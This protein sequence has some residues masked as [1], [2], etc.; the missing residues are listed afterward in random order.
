MSKKTLALLVSLLLVTVVLLGLALNS[1]KNPA[2]QTKPL[3]LIGNPEPTSV[4]QT[5]MSMSPSTI[6][7]GPSGTGTVDVVLTTDVNEVSAV[8]LELSYDPKVLTGVIV[9]QGT[10]FDNPLVLINTNDTK[11]GRISYALGVSQIQASHKGTGTVATISFRKAAGASVTQ[12]K[13]SFLPKSLVSAKG[14]S[15]SVLKSTTDTTIT[16]GQ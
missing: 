10:F 3:P 5:I 8:Q 9:K 13:I 16:L 15:P 1:S 12:T 4:E 11:T 2:T 6:Q 14:V 7:L